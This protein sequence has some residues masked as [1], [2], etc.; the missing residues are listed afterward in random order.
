MIVDCN[1]RNMNYRNT[2]EI[3]VS[4]SQIKTQIIHFNLYENVKK[5]TMLK[6]TYR[7]V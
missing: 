7:S 5:K 6:Y 1:T 3:T 2:F 4:E